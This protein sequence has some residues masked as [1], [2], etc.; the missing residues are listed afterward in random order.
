MHGNAS[1]A[2][3]QFRNPGGR[4][5]IVRTVQAQSHIYIYMALYKP[6]ASNFQT[7]ESATNCE[8]VH[9]AECRSYAVGK[10]PTIT[11][12]LTSDIIFVVGRASSQSAVTISKWHLHLTFSPTVEPKSRN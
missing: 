7:R 8:H 2:E 9:I 6:I 11:Q 10:S 1:L 4:T 12:I 5:K 3:V